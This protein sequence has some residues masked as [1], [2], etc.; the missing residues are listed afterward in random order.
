[1][2]IV[3]TWS[4]TVDTPMGAQPAELVL[5]ADGTGSTS[6]A[7]GSSTIDDLELDGDRATFTVTIDVMGRE[8]VLRGS[9]T[10][11]GNSITGRYE[12]AQGTS[13]FTGGRA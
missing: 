5:N 11:E 8:M 4:I 1:M 3:G 12:T 9:A 2:S 7:M 6:S 13:A 10:A